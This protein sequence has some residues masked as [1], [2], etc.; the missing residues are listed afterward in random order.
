M[1]SSSSTFNSK[2]DS[3]LDSRRNLKDYLS[4]NNTK[5]TITTTT[6]VN[7]FN[8]FNNNNNNI[9]NNNTSSTSPSKYSILQGTSSISKSRLTRS[10]STVSNLVQLFNPSS[11]SITGPRLITQDKENHHNSPQLNSRTTTSNIKDQLSSSSSNNSTF[12]PSFDQP[13][14]I[15]SRPSS[16]SSSRVNIT[17]GKR[18]VANLRARWDL[19]KQFDQSLQLASM[20]IGPAVIASVDQKEPNEEATFEAARRA[21]VTPLRIKKSSSST[22][23]KRVA[24]PSIIDSP[25]SSPATPIRRS[26]RTPSHTPNSTLA[27]RTPKKS[28]PTVS[29]TFQTTTITASPYNPPVSPNP[30]D[31]LKVRMQKLFEKRNSERGRKGDLS[32]GI[33]SLSMRDFESHQTSGQVEGPS[34]S[35]GLAGSGHKRVNSAVDFGKMNRVDLDKALRTLLSTH[36]SR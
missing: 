8:D 9:N 25:L 5:A 2:L 15:E 22:L 12:N 21:A 4:S 30:T 19:D 13:F 36:C 32:R 17:A 6:T 33:S 26:T 23:I 3:N 31:L 35:G 16:T 14:Q 11:S 1:S 24:S 7:Q 20:S 10:N 28:P 29:T 27:L 34:S 18:S